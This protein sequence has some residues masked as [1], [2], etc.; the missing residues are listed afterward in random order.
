MK[1]ICLFFI[2]IIISL[3]VQTTLP[4]YASETSDASKGQTSFYGKYEFKED[5]GKNPPSD[6]NRLP[7]TG[8]NTLPQTGDGINPLYSVLGI[9]LILIVIIL[10]IQRQ[11]TKKRNKGEY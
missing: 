7:K 1:R 8:G 11:N 2:L 9:I 4:T 6:L 3:T 10:I 5:K